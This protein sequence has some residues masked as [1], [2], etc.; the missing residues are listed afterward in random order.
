MKFIKLSILLFS[1]L[2]FFSCAEE[3]RA[4]DGKV[5]ISGKITNA[6]SGKLILS[7]YLD[8]RAEVIDTIKISGN[9]KFDYEV[10]L[11]GP[12]FFELNIL[13]KKSV[14]LALYDEDIEISYDIEDESSYKISGSEDSKHLMKIDELAQAYQEEI[15]NLNSA[16]YEAMTNKDQ[17]AIVEIQNKAM[18]LE[19]THAE[20]VKSA[21][22]DMDGSFASLAAL[23]MLNF[24]NDFLFVDELV[25]KLNEKYPNT[26]MITSLKSQLDDMRLLSIGQEAPEISLPNPDGDLVSLSDL[27][28]KYVL[29]DF[30]AAWC[31]PCREENP[32]VVRLF[33]KYNDAG[34]E[35]F[36]VS[37]D[38]TKDAWVKAIAEDGL[39]WTHVS[40]LQYF[41]SAAA[42]TYQINAIPATYLLD[43]DGK[44]IAKDLRG[45]SLEKKLEEIF[46][47]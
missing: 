40:D 44:I 43:P 3:K 24:K 26:K 41:N 12:T 29:I 5:K 30:W 13:D 11:D 20:K 17:A 31:R 39:T 38:R 27:R 4:F 7:K 23:G 35:V 34:F 10:S 37:L 2:L 14:R 42:A 18:D 15:N 16:Y 8:D 25:E 47:S 21:I 36:G 9:G 45:S 6:E 19:S 33:N 46:G 32:N 22:A 1:T 28:G